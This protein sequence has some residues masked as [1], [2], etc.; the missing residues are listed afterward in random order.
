MRAWSIISSDEQKLN[1]RTSETA[2][3][4]YWV[5]RESKV[6]FLLKMSV[7]N[8]II[9]H[10]KDGKSSTKIWTTLKNLYQTQNTNHILSLNGKLFSMG[11]EDTESDVGLIPRVKYLKDRLGDIGEKVSD[12]DLVTITLNRMMD[13]YQMFITGFSAWDYAPAFEELTG[14]SFQEEN[15]Q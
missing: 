12:S 9:P 3:I 13:E 15:W 1:S 14:I 10:I 2:L 4:Q 11:M 5:K 7:K 8:N 6:T